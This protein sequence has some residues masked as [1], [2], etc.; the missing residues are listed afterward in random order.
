M[1]D[2][3]AKMLG[4]I[5]ILA[6]FF[7]IAFNSL[8][9]TSFSILDT[10]AS[11][12]IIVVMLMLFLFILFSA[13]E[14]LDFKYDYRN[15]IY[16]VVVFAV[17]AILLSYLRVAL[18]STFLSYRIDAL[19]FPLPLLGL[20]FLIFGLSS[21]RKL[22]PLIIYSVFASPLL[23]VPILNLG[24]AFAN[25]NAI[26]VYGIVKSFGL[27]VSKIGLVISS[28]IGPS[29]TIS[30]TCVSI[31]TFAA[32]VMFLLPIAYVY[33]GK[34]S[35]KALWI[36]SGTALMLLLNFL[37][38]LLISLVWVYYGITRA[39]NIF[40]LFAGQLIFYAVIIIMVLIAYKYGLSIKRAKRTAKSAS[41]VRKVRNSRLPI[42][43]ALAFVFAIISFAL[44]SGYGSSINAHYTLFQGNETAGSAVINRMILTNIENANSNITILNTTNTV[45]LFLIGNLSSNL[46][47]SIYAIT[48]VSKS[49]IG[50]S[51]FLSY[52]PSGKAHSYLLKNGITVTSQIV[53]SGPGKFYIN[54]FSVPHEVGNN[55]IMVNYMLFMNASTGTQK[56]DV[57]IHDTDYVSTFDSHVYNFLNSGSGNTGNGFMCQSYLIAAAK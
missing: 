39:V 6:A 37:R 23:L 32:F 55:W 11:T 56:C 15:V 9:V 30:S 42:V 20:A 49:P 14:D 7:I 54:H 27:Q 43:I 16:S 51:E 44:N 21:I 5:V 18:S 22:Y 24:T 13:K 2:R 53:Y 45:D 4:I 46:N 1:S 19:L 52:V 47:D 50:I 12:Y 17:Y 33:E 34:L 41:R 40:H 10:D 57:P 36:V 31:G 48:N 29:I 28:G 35:R 26:F 8:S 3:R 25:V 38:M